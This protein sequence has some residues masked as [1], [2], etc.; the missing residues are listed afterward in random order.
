MGKP[1]NKRTIFVT[2]AARLLADYYCLEH[3]PLA[4]GCNKYSKVH[5]D[6]VLWIVENLWIDNIEYGTHVHINSNVTPPYHK[7][8][9]LQ[10]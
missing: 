7:Y 2:K 3:N 8:L 9:H 10:N 5:I 1:G 6:D 4:F